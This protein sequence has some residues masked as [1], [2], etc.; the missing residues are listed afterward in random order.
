[1]LSDDDVDV[2][3]NLETLV[4]FTTTFTTSAENPI[5]LVSD[6]DDANVVTHQNASKPTVQQVKRE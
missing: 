4:R 2:K 3:P 5:D 1:M 6:D